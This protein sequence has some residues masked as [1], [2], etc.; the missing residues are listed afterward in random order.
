MGNDDPM[1]L[2]MC[3]STPWRVLAKT[4]P[5]F[6]TELDVPPVIVIPP[7]PPHCHIASW[8][9]LPSR[10]WQRPWVSTQFAVCSVGTPNSRVTKHLEETNDMTGFCTMFLESEAHSEHDLSDLKKNQPMTI[11]NPTGCGPHADGSP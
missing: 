10:T 9:A 3:R 4:P 5:V 2:P 11:P 1:G 8:W 6:G 7:K